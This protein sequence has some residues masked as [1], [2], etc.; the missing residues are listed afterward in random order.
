MATLKS[1]SKSILVFVLKAVVATLLIGWLVKSGSLDLA[2]LGLLFARPSLLQQRG[3]G[4]GGPR[5]TARYRA[6]TRVPVAC[7]LLG[8][9]QARS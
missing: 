9:N 5:V 6:A 1:R 7:G 2:A 8:P 3:P 4:A